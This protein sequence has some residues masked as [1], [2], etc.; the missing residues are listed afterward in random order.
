MRIIVAPS[1]LADLARLRAFL[2]RDNPVAAE[3]AAAALNTAIQSLDAFPERGRPSGNNSNIRE[4]I[5]SFGKSGYVLR[6]A[7]R[8][9]A[10]EVIVVRIWH[11]REMRE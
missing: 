6:Y 2:A 10:Q 9:E 5:V 1:A 8:R 11:G 7:Y 4:L 3:R